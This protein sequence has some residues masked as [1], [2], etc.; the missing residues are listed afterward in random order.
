MEWFFGR[1]FMLRYQL[2][3]YSKEDKI[4]IVTINRPEFLNALNEDLYNELNDLFQ[5]L[6]REQDIHVVILT[7][8]GDKAFVAGADIASMHRLSSV[9]IRGFLSTSRK[10]FD[11]VYNFSKPVIAA[12]NGFALGGGCELA[13]CCDLRIASENAKFGQPEVN[14]GI[15][16]GGG[17]TQRLSRLL[18]MTKAKELLYT[19]DIIDAHT[20]LSVGLVNKVVAATDLMREA[21]ALAQKIG[22]KSLPVLILAKKAV[23]SGSSMDLL[24]GLDFEAECFAECFALED[25][26]EGM[27]AFLQKRKP[28]FKNR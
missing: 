12:I 19:G 8:S 21:K 15:I 25:Q 22:S 28:V 10:A 24:S 2:L 1:R 6:E 26:K 9:E 23:N 20:A 16:P 7:G 4:G 11:R 5:E 3:L 17:G 14:L 27:D 13:M 18:G